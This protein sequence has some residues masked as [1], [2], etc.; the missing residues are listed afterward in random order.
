MRININGYWFERGLCM[1][2]GG[3]AAELGVLFVTGH[4]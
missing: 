3:L 2:L 4:F 1:L